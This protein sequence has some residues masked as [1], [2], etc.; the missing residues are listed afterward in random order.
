[1]A[2]P[3]VPESVRLAKVL[4]ELA[5]AVAADGGAALYLDDGDCALS[6]AATSGPASAGRSWSSRLLRRSPDSRVLVAP[7][8][9]QEGGGS[10][11]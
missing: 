4:A 9:E 1:L 3:I 8:P 6:L 2:E 5:T 7:L 10:V 11:F